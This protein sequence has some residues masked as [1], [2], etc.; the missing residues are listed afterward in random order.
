MVCPFADICLNDSCLPDDST[1]P[2]FNLPANAI[3]SD[4][5]SRADCTRQF[6]LKHW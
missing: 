3:N 4:I 1:N 6:G 2:L 5:P